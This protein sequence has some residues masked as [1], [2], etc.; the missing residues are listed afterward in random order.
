MEKRKE[1]TKGGK[2]LNAA[3]KARAIRWGQWLA[4]LKPAL[5]AFAALIALVASTAAWFANNKEVSSSDSSVTSSAPDTNLYIRLA[6]AEKAFLSKVEKSWESA[7]GLYPIST[8]DCQ[9]WYYVD[10]WELRQTTDA[11]TQTVTGTYTPGSYAL[12]AADANGLYT[13][14]GTQRRAWFS[15]AYNLYTSG[16]NLDIY[17]NPDTPISVTTGDRKLDQ[18]IRVALVD[19]SGQPLLIYAPTAEDTFQ[20]VTDANS[21]ANLSNVKVGKVGLSDYWAVV[22]SEAYTPGKTKL[23]TATGEGV[24]ITVYVWLEGTDAQA[25]IGSSDSETTGITVSVNFVGVEASQP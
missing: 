7:V 19:G 12:A 2:Y 10:S 18:A 23:C 8:A 15:T 1:K 14:K 4:L 17:L 6:G 25:V 20:A 5:F 13:N 22:G 3:G 21:V 11:G 24:D 16:A 9:K